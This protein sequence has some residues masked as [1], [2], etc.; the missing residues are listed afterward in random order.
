MEEIDSEIG[1]VKMNLERRY[2]EWC[3]GPANLVWRNV[4]WFLKVKSEKARVK[5]CLANQGAQWC[6]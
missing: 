5:N 6:H 1:E 3:V 2:V 4:H